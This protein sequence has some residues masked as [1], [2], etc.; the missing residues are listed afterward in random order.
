MRVLAPKRSVRWVAMYGIGAGGASP[1]STRM[2]V[3]NASARINISIATRRTRVSYCTSRIAVIRGDPSEH[4]G[5]HLSHRCEHSHC[6]CLAIGRCPP[7]HHRRV[8]H[9]GLIRSR[10]ISH[11]ASRPRSGA[12]GQGRGPALPPR[13]TETTERPGAQHPYAFRIPHLAPSRLTA[14]RTAP[15]LPQQHCVDLRNAAPRNA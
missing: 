10:H 9:R 12:G 3:R 14:P 13:P 1:A 8:M 5:S 4:L 7:H 11:A 2:N 15:P 6:H